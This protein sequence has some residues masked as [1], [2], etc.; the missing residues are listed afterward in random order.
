MTAMQ[1]MHS[2]SDGS[3]ARLQQSEQLEE[4]LVSARAEATQATYESQRRQFLQF[5]QQLGVDGEQ[6]FS[7]QVLCL[8]IMGR[9]Q[10]GYK[11][12]TIE[13]GLHALGALD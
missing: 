10:H 1:P 4:F 6:R 11:L 2:W 7:T 12:S 3:W 13:I 5:C 9:A 8:W